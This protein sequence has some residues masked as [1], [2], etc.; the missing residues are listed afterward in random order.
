MCQ[1]VCQFPYIVSS[2]KYTFSV[3]KCVSICVCRC[4]CRC[5]IDQ[6]KITKVNVSGTV[7]KCILIIFLLLEGF[8]SGVTC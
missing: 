3:Y 6:V 4:F 5:D 7:N 1:K 2:C 8:W